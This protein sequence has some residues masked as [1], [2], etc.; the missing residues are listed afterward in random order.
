M[1]DNLKESTHGR[2]VSQRKTEMSLI[3]EY[4]TKTTINFDR[5]N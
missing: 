2:I 1:K 3:R 4:D 5:I